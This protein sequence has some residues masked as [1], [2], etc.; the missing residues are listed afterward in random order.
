M[1]TILLVLAAIL[2]SASLAGQ[3]VSFRSHPP[4]RPLPEPARRPMEGGAARFVDAAK[5]DDGNPG[6]RAEPWKTLAHALKHSTAGET[7]YLRGGTYYERVVITAGGTREKPLTVRSFPGE[8]AVLDGGLREF[9]ETPEAAWEPFPGEAKREFRSTRAYPGLVPASEAREGVALLGRFGDSM[10]P[11]HGYR[12][13]IDFR[14]QNEYWNLREKLD[15]ETGIYCGPGLWYD[16]ETSRIH[17]RLSHTGLEA[18]GEDNYRG[19]TDPRKLRLVVA[20]HAGGSPLTVR[21]AK[22]L[23]VQD[24]VVRGARLAGVDVYDAEDVEF[25]GVTV[26]GG[27]SAFRVM[28]TRGFRMRHCACR[29]IAAPWTFRASLKYRAIEARIFSASEW[30]PTGADNTDFELAHNEFTD[31][32]DGIFIGNVKGVRFHHNLVDNISDDGIFLTAGTAYDGSTPGGD[33]HIYQNLLSRCLTTF[34]FGVGH[35]RQKTLPSGKQTGSGVKIYRN[36]FDFRRP[37]PYQIPPGP[38]VREL[39]SWARVASDHGGPAWEPMD[40]YQNTVISYDAPF[41]SYYGAGLGGHMGLG[42]RRR[43]FNNLFVQVEGMPGEVL[44][45]TDVDFQADGNL[46][47]S[48]SDGPAFQGDFLARF[49]R[50]KALADSKARYA[51]G[52]VAGDRFADPRFLLFNRDWKAP[53]DLRLAAGSPAVDAGVALPA[54]W[55]DPLRAGAPGKPDLGALP[56]NVLPW[57]VGV[58]GR[59]SVTGSEQPSRLI[60]MPPGGWTPLPGAGEKPVRKPAAIVQGYPAYDAPLIRFALRRRGVSVDSLERT[61]LDTRDYRKYGL[62]VIAGDLVRAK[63]EPNRFGAEDLPRVRAFLEQGSTLL[64]MRGTTALFGA[65]EGREFLAAL[66]GTCPPAREIR[67]EIRQPDHPW[68]KHLQPSGPHPWVMARHAQPVRTGRGNVIIGDATGHATLYRVPVGKGALIYVGWEIAA[69]LP[70]GRKPSTVEDERLF[71]EQMRII[72]Q[73]ASE[74]YP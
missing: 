54:G 68:V 10:I 18:L 45:S 41:R 61:W 38:E 50:S 8:L 19:E 5:G 66:T 33:V 63:I 70:E 31:S 53:L 7:L 43:V 26:Y 1:A 2:G 24:L 46:H 72:L 67:L 59:L 60:G 42:T 64:L 47:W 52:W 14:S 22:H 13:R 69:S 51:P 74:L 40:V 6:S 17:V 23:R 49:R 44:P 3:P 30:D 11:L 55:P 28:D 56:S 15:T 32:V 73:L 34:A 71:E 9:F 21:G 35:G 37:V 16:P 12:H 57:A 58:T 36:V 48:I 25:D 20:G 4:Q 62:V 39:T 27:S 29:G 65:P